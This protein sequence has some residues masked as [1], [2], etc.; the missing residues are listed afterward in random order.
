MQY[1]HA[2]IC[3]LQ[4]QLQLIESLPTVDYRYTET[5]ERR[6]IVHLQ[7]WQQVL[8]QAAENYQPHL[9]TNYLEQLAQLFHSYYNDYK[10]KGEVESVQQGRFAL[11]M[12]VK[13]VLAIGLDLIGVAAPERM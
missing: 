12:A 1:A 4:S 6:L 11:C 7:L 5:I 8:M 9:V 2:R 13:Q 10:I 3:S